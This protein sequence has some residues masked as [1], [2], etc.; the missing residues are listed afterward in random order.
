MKG[1]ETVLGPHEVEIDS[2]QKGNRQVPKK[3]NYLGRS[4]EDCPL[5]VYS[6]DN[7]VSSCDCCRCCRL[8]L[9]VGGCCRRWPVM[10]SAAMG[11][12]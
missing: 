8:G 6:R 2:E 10:G 9:V 12:W 7:R 1:D 3:I 5:L 4:L 11:A